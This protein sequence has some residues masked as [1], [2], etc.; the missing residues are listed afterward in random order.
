[1]DFA[2]NLLSSRRG[3]ILL[4]AGAALIAAILLIVY[5]SHYRSSLKASDET[6]Q[7]LVAKNLIQK[8]APGNLIARSHGYQIALIPKK[9]VKS[10]A[11]T[12]TSTLAGLVA[13][14][15]IYAN[16][17]MTTADFVAVAPNSIQTNLV[18]RDRAISIPLDQAHGMIN[19]LSPG[20][21]VDVYV[22]LEM[23]GPGGTQPIM[24]Q[25]MEN[26][27]VLRTPSS[28][29]GSGNIVLRASGAQAAALAFAADNGK[30]WLV[31]RP[32]SGAKPA[33][34]GLVTVQRLLLGVRPVG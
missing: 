8:G 27:L 15:D 7:V 6:T 34:P 1:M 11:I 20:D 26:S 28:G 17:Q 25:L 24:K 2:E 10:G 19:E 16:Q 4:G 29:A 31:M 23:Q 3:T 5:L 33:K 12:D 22:G 9:T 14:H 21:H 18:G 32:A 30:L 13:A